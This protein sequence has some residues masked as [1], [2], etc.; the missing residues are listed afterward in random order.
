MIDALEGQ[1]FQTLRREDNLE[2]SMLDGRL[3]ATL[4]PRDVRVGDSIDWPM[5]SGRSARLHVLAIR[6]QPEAAGE[7]HR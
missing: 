7:L 6:F 3:T 5:P 1:T 2:S 4:Q